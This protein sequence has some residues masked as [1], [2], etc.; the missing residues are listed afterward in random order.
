M[1]WTPE[2]I[3]EPAPM[4]T[5]SPMVAKGWMSTF[6][7]D[8]GGRA[9]HRQRA[10]ADARHRPRRTEMAHDG[11]ERPMDVVDLDG[12]QSRGVKLAGATTAAARQFSRRWFFSAWSTSVIW[13]G[14]A[15]R[16]V[17]APRITNWPSPT[18]CPPTSAASSAR[19][20]CMMRIPFPDEPILSRPPDRRS[21]ESEAMEC[22]EKFRAGQEQLMRCLP[23]FSS[24]PRESP[25]ALPSSLHTS[26]MLFLV[27]EGRLIVAQQF[28][29]G[30]MGETGEFSVP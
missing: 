1:M 29:A 24:P 16:S 21:R 27:P 13:P 18:I 19:V 12:R 5:S 3:V 14:S 26:R 20:A 7:A 15:S 9:D 28:T 8:L 25:G 2:W 17:A 22:S 30:K 11:G 10:D 6:A 23:I 4:V